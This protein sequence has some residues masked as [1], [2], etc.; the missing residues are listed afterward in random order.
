MVAS[1]DAIWIQGGFITLV[2]LFYRVGLRTNIGKTVGMVF[3]QCH[4]TGIQLEAAYV[5]RMM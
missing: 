2:G 4:A 1:P 5:R 3:H